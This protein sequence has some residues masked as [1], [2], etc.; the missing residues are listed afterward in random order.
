[1]FEGNIAQ[2]APQEAPISHVKNSIQALYERLGLR[3]WE[4]SSKFEEEWVSPTT[5]LLTGTMEMEATNG[6]VLK[7]PFSCPI[8]FEEYSIEIGNLE[9]TSLPA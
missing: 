3:V 4:G 2:N 5:L 8:N 7:V 1:M 9:A 6:V